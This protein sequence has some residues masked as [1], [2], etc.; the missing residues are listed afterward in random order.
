MSISME[1]SAS[2]DNIELNIEKI[3]DTIT[4]D[5]PALAGDNL[6]AA[7][8]ATAIAA[9]KLE[10]Q[11]GDTVISSPEDSSTDDEDSHD[12][13]KRPNNMPCQGFHKEIVKKKGTTNRIHIYI[14]PP[15]EHAYI[16]RKAI[17]DDKIKNKR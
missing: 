6:E 11:E 15:A 3:P 16:I 5:S 2:S 8:I 7:Q 14:Y 13:L 4:S 10:K 12:L 9:S 1:N 17:N